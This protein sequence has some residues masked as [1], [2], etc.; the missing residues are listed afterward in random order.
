MR[1]PVALVL[2]CSLLWGVA[3]GAQAADN[4]TP[5]QAKAADKE[6]WLSPTD[7]QLSLSTHLPWGA[8]KEP[9]SATNE[10]L[11]VQR[12]YVID[13]DDDLRIPIWTA[14]RIVAKNLKSG[15]TNCFRQDVRL[16]ASV[17][18]SPTDY[19][20]PIFDQ[21]HMTPN[22]DQSMNLTATLNSFVMSNM[23]PQFCQFNRGVWQILEVLVRRWADEH[24]TIYVISGSVLDRDGDGARDPDS[25]AIRM[26]SNN[27]QKRVAIPSAFYKII[28]FKNPDGSLSTLTILLPHD[29]TDVDGEDAITY[30]KQH[31]NSIAA[32]HGLTGLSYFPGNAPAIS[33]ASTLWSFT[34]SPPQSLAHMGAQCAATA[35]A[36]IN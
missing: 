27:K 28:A 17:A 22:G 18:S 3:G 21:G 16:R 26:K 35:G 7:Q 31:V 19:A 5:A 30:L 1:F 23:T 14:H 10:H 32:V 11:L 2:T 33:E 9:A 20:E 4:C 8:P 12:D 15:R 24:G 34:G 29:Q 25:A 6:L 36:V 13:Y